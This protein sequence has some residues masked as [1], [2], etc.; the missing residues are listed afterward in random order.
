M[1]AFFF[2]FAL[3]LSTGAGAQSPPDFVLSED[4]LRSLAQGSKAVVDV[5]V[6]LTHRTNNVH[7]LANDC[8]MH[9]A[10]TPTGPELADPTS[11]VVEPPNLCKFASASGSGW[12]AVFDQQVIN[13]NCIATGY[14]RIFTEHAASGSEGGANPNHVLEIHPALRIACGPDVIDFT[15]YL[16]FFPGMR[17]IKP[18]TAND[19][20]RNRTVSMRYDPS[21]HR[22]EFLEQGGT[23]GNFVIAEV[24]F[25]EPKW[26]QAI[27]GGHAAIARVSLDGQSRTTL[28]LYTLAGTPAD[29]WLAAVKTNGLGAD[30]VYVHGM[31]TYDYFAF[32]KA[33]RSK[34]THYWINPAIWTKVPHPI[35]LVVFGFPTEA[36]WDDQD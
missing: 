20:I 36:P 3:L 15:S 13:K 7:A 2:S 33:M 18:S 26:I 19:C 28:K 34:T 30:R 35:S 27:N 24:G 1:R 32:V 25:V 16:T 22:Y 31:I 11:V 10:G 17:S 8:E 21:G 29:Q 4:Y 12:G 6:V 14:P 9:L 23:C 5:P